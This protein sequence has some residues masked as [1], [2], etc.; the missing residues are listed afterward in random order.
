MIV[1]LIL[2]FSLYILY[3]A[4]SSFFAVSRLPFASL[5]VRKTRNKSNLI[6]IVTATFPSRNNSANR[7]I[8]L[9]SKGTKTPKSSTRKLN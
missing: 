4:L 7:T 8:T 3:Y 5:L 1:H 6:S 9:K 2:S